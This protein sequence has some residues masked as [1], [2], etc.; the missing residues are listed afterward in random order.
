MAGIRHDGWGTWVAAG[1][2]VANARLCAAGGAALWPNGDTMTNWCIAGWDKIHADC[3]I[4]DRAPAMAD[5]DGE[6]V[7]SVYS[8]DTRYIHNIGR[9]GRY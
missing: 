2:C 8:G 9:L 3:G 7:V 5:W 6:G 1:S 4:A